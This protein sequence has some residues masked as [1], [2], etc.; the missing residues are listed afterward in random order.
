MKSDIETFFHQYKDEYYSYL[1]RLTGERTTAEDLL[2]DSFLKMA[3]RLSSLK[4][5][6]KFR[7][8]G[9]ALVGNT[10]RDWY[11]RQK[12]T[13]NWEQETMESVA[14]PLSQGSPEEFMRQ[15]LSMM[16]DEERRVFILSHFENQGHQEIAQLTGLSERTV[17]RRMEN[18]VN[19]FERVL[20]KA[21]I[22]RGDH[23]SFEGF[24]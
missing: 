23:F 18:A 1:L 20:M 8:W 21:N 4:D 2:H 19:L 7:S 5:E 3:E 24:I 10:F 12:K 9:Y 22:I 15:V 11:R 17:R 13:V 6:S 16:G 14:A